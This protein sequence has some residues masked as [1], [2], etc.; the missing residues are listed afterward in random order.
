MKFFVVKEPNKPYMCRLE[1]T[2]RAVS[3]FLD[4][5]GRYLQIVGDGEEVFPGVFEDQTVIFKGER[6]EEQK[7]CLCLVEGR[8]EV[9]KFLETATLVGASRGMYSALFLL[10]EN[11]KVYTEMYTY[12]VDDE[13]NLIAQTKRERLEEAIQLGNVEWF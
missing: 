13:G 4:Q 2:E 5:N 8:N 9:G 3:L 6:R 12:T 7:K 11:R 1:D 10:P